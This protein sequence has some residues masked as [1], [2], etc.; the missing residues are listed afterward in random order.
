[1]THSTPVVPVSPPDW[2]YPYHFVKATPAAPA[3]PYAF[4]IAKYQDAALNHIKTADERRKQRTAERRSELRTYA[5][6]TL[7]EPKRKMITETVASRW[8][9]DPTL[10]TGRRL[11]ART[12]AQARKP[13]MESAWTKDYVVRPL[14]QPTMGP[15]DT[16]FVGKINWFPGEPPQTVRQ[17]KPMAYDC[18]GNAAGRQHQI[19]IP[20]PVSETGESILYAGFAPRMNRYGTQPSYRQF[21]YIWKGTA[22]PRR[23]IT[24]VQPL[25]SQRDPA[26][27]QQ[28]PETPKSK[29]FDRTAIDVPHHGGTWTFDG[30]RFASYEAAS[31]AMKQKLA[32]AKD[33]QERHARLNKIFTHSLRA[34][35]ENLREDIR[36]AC[37]RISR[38]TH[39]RVFVDFRVLS[40]I[41]SSKKIFEG[42]APEKKRH[43][44]VR[45]LQDVDYALYRA[46]IDKAARPNVVTFDE[47]D[48][49][50]DA[51]NGHPIYLYALNGDRFDLATITVG[52]FNG[53]STEACGHLC[54]QLN[55]DQLNWFRQHLTTLGKE[56]GGSVEKG[57]WS[58]L[59]TE[60]SLREKGKD[61][62]FNGKLGSHRTSGHGKHGDRGNGN[63][64]G[65]HDKNGN[66][67]DRGKKHGGKHQNGKGKFQKDGGK[68]SGNGNGNGHNNSGHKNGH[69]HSGKQS[70][71]GGP[72]HAGA[73]FKQNGGGRGHN[74]GA[75]GG[76]SRGRGK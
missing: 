68:P 32:I 56:G 53:E 34:A 45:S 29:I 15:I 12:H 27:A 4:D 8:T 58:S 63:G 71:G 43:E 72:K 20:L 16:R 69:H 1:M 10:V 55:L 31:E 75:R 33:F 40:P 50:I 11:A 57:R 46:A 2:M 62:W 38:K 3:D 67:S 37:E 28:E 39:M 48:M 26:A 36:I 66:D 5:R 7:W 44:F 6:K 22:P 54:V 51:E 74:R 30:Q 64:K 24:R 70:N 61:G 52:A 76:G 17:A 35:N 25:S 49:Y 73:G 41:T 14:G 18:R 47:T 13:D 42:K 19:V 21:S 60:I 65:R 9:N 23:T 59:L